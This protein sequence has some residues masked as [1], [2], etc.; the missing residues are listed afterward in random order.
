MT[1]TH[2]PWGFSTWFYRESNFFA[3]HQ[4]TIIISIPKYTAMQGYVHPLGI[5]ISEYPGVPFVS[6]RIFVFRGPKIY[7]SMVAVRL[8]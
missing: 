3:H 6:W 1:I 8:V 2:G 5:K 4:M 7:Q